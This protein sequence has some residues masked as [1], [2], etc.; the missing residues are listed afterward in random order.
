[1]GE[2]LT[3]LKIRGDPHV[4]YLS[5]MSSY[6]ST[7]L[8]PG[9]DLVTHDMGTLVGTSTQTCPIAET[10]VMQLCSLVPSPPRTPMSMGMERRPSALSSVYIAFAHHT[11]TPPTLLS[12]DSNSRQRCVIIPSSSRRLNAPPRRPRS[13]LPSTTPRCASSPVQL[14][15]NTQND[16]DGSEVLDV[17]DAEHVTT[18]KPA[19]APPAPNKWLVV[20]SASLI[21]ALHT[22]AVSTTASTLLHPMRLSLG[23]SLA[24]A[25]RPI[26]LFRALLT[27]FLFP[28]SFA[29][30]RVGAVRCVR[31]FVV[32]AA[33]LAPLQ[34][35]ATSLPHLLVLHAAFAVTKIFAGIPTLL[36]VAAR[37]CGPGQGLGSATAVV[38]SGYSLAGFV[39]PSLLG[40]LS[41]RFGWRIAAFTVSSIFGLICVP[42]VLRVFD[43]AKI[44]T[45]DDEEGASQQPRAG[46]P[47]NQNSAAVSLPKRMIIEEPLHHR[48]RHHPLVGKLTGLAKHF[49]HEVDKQRLRVRTALSHQAS[50]GPRTTTAITTATSTA[51]PIV[52]SDDKLLTL[53]YV[54]VLVSVGCFNMSLFC[55]LDHFI[56]FLVDEVHLPFTTATRYLSLFNLAALLSKL[57][58]GP[59]SDA[60][61]RSRLLVVFGAAACVSN[62]LLFTA[63]G[64]LTASTARIATFLLCYA[65]SYSGVFATT[66][67]ILPELGMRRLAMR[68]NLN[69]A[70]ALAGG[71][72]GTWL[73]TTFKTTTGSYALS[74]A[75]NIVAYAVVTACALMNYVLRKR[76]LERERVQ[77][78]QEQEQLIQGQRFALH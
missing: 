5:D 4:V 13:A 29:I 71:S 6:L 16:Q 1:M 3:Q 24:E 25:T 59:L 32:L 9:F 62:M 43:P 26:L 21:Y 77:R 44:K 45:E 20:V 33:I 51:T 75:L 66:A 8:C 54:C 70:A 61:D 34:A 38:L 78:E 12:G 28:S 23:L 55:I 42:L 69:T 19:P 41:A 36:Y 56:L 40:A 67:S 50:S 65:C 49:G 39:F 47:A 22:T 52:D 31:I 17:H 15:S 37:V 2:T 63:G 30:R 76:R 58:C 57:G 53:E 7:H 18:T 10:W 72:L 73:A 64:A 35:F 68:S 60:V 14:P 27:V 74:F 48:D 46:V 11:A